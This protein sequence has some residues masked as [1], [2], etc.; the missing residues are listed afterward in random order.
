MC[1]E[2]KE[3]VHQKRV[4]LRTNH[5]NVARIT[6]RPTGLLPLCRPASTV[7]SMMIVLGLQ[8][9]SGHRCLS[10]TE[11]RMHQ[12][13]P[14]RPTFWKRLHRRK[15]DRA[16]PVQAILSLRRNR[17]VCLFPPSACPVAVVFLAWVVPHDLSVCHIY[18]PLLTATIQWDVGYWATVTHGFIAARYPLIAW[19]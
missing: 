17:P 19:L 2:K 14:T 8:R 18:I 15:C 11:L 1:P 12:A 5:P 6:I 10:Q 9:A 16:R 7:L 13:V 3:A 4:E